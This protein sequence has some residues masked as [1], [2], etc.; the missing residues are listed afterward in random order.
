M[1]IN[2]CHIGGLQIIEPDIFED[3]RGY[4]FESYNFEKYNDVVGQVFLQDSE[5]YSTEH[6]LRGLHLQCSPHSQGKLVRVV[7]GEIL[8]VAVDL[9]LDSETF[10]QH[11]SVVLS[12]E[13]KKQLWIPEGFAHG[14]VTRSEL[15]IFSYK[16]TA[17]YKK[18]AE[19]TLAWNDPV[20]NI[21]WEIQNPIISEKDAEGLSFDE[22]K[23]A[24]QIL[25]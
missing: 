21:D 3:T 23:K 18:S 16:C 17:Y 6:V 12:G 9:R 25:V 8:D 13:N 7:T 14:F 5:S 10:G 2:K 19:M 20:L 4:F 15:A 24:L 11:F 22:C 1:Q